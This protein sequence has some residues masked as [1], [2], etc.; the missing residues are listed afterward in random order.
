[1]SLKEVLDNL[2]GE[3]KEYFLEKFLP[4][5]N[6]LDDDDSA[7]VTAAA[8]EIRVG[9]GVEYLRATRKDEEAITALEEAALDN[10]EYYVTAAELCVELGMNDR[11]VSN[12]E[13]AGEIKKAAEVYLGVEYTLF[14]IPS[15]LEDKEITMKYAA[16]L[17]AK[18][19]TLEGAQEHAE[20]ARLGERFGMIDSAI[21]NYDLAGNHEKVETLSDI[22]SDPVKAAQVW[23]RN[24]YN[25]E[26]VNLLLLTGFS[27]ELAET[28][29]RAGYFADAGS[30]YETLRDF[31]SALR[32][33][34]QAESVSDVE[35]I[36]EEQGREE[37]LVAYWRETGNTLKLAEHFEVSDP[38]KASTL[39][40]ESN[41]PNRAAGSLMKAGKFVEAIELAF[42]NKLYET[43]LEEI[44]A[45]ER[46]RALDP[47]KIDELKTRSYRELAPRYEASDPEKALDFYSKLE[48]QEG[49]KR[50]ATNLR[51]QAKAKGEFLTASMY[52]SRIGDEKES[53]VL[54]ETGFLLISSPQS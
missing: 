3:S 23:E 29:E 39:Y 43:A 47:S 34:K 48:D 30:T 53:Q 35:R 2:S 8:L 51:D 18:I 42:E 49:I 16:N 26:A 54:R 22:S 11:A 4:H 6:T 38:E 33:Y 15:R 5:A 36:L 46:M 21:N 17:V 37:E 52:A 13:H 28:Q 31:D 41:D 7:L 10:P 45:L 32:S 27:K 24:G 9:L 1:M 50:V 20:A 40:L 44:L 12:Y 25:I 14:T 19:D